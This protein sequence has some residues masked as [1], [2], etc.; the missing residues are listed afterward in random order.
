MKIDYRT[1]KFTLYNLP[2]KHSGPYSVSADKTRNRIGVNE[3]VEDKIARFDPKTNTFM[4]F[5]LPTLNSDVRRIE[6]DRSRPT[7]IWFS[8][9]GSGG[10]RGG[11]NVGG[12]YD[13]VGYL[14]VLE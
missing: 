2:T 13:K 8:G 9:S 6:V 3:H 11:S 1:D 12:S 7:R 5:S 10:A 4:E 14:E